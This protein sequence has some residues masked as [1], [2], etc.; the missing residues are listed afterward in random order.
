VGKEYRFSQV[1]LML[2]HFGNFVC[3]LVSFVH[4]S[5]SL[6]LFYNITLFCSCWVLLL[7]PVN[8]DGS[9]LGISISWSW[10]VRI[11]QLVNDIKERRERECVKCNDIIK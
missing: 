11:N 2:V 10:L 1:R 3:K 6:L 4:L 8:Y 7:M 9:T 5:Y